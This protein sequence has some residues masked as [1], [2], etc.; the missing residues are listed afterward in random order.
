MAHCEKTWH[1]HAQASSCASIYQLHATRVCAERGRDSGRGK[2]R[3]RKET[4]RKR[5]RARERDERQT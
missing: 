4:A 5:E 2:E 3:P 1:L